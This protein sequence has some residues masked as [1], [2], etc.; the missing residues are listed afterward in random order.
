[1]THKRRQADRP[2]DIE[3]TSEMVWAG[4]RALD[5]AWETS[6]SSPPPE[7]ISALAVEVF[8]AMLKASSRR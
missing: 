3:I 7:R 1:M 4:F 6:P 5:G 8:E 2:R